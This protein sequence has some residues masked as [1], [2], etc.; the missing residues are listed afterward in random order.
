LEAVQAMSDG[1]RGDVGR[2]RFALIIERMAAAARQRALLGGA[3]G[4]GWAR[5]WERLSAL[6]GMVEGLNL[7]RADAIS[8]ALSEIDAAGR[9]ER[10]A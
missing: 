9:A 2:I 10:A 5:A 3:A 7:D 8:V 6:T 1:L 4:E